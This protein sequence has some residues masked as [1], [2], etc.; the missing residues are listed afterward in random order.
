MPAIMKVS[1]ANRRGLGSLRSAYVAVAVERYRRDHGS[2]PDTLNALVPNYLPALPTDPQDGAPLRFKRTPDGVVVYWLGLDGIDN[3]GK[4]N[5]LNYLAQGSDQG[6]QLWDVKQRRQPA[7]E[8]L[9][10]PRE[11]K[12]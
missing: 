5:R 9:Q 10:M 1:E 3:G 6:F 8:V 12:Q 7:R 2:W 4:L 11:G